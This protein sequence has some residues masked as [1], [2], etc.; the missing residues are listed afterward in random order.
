MNP[1]NKEFLNIDL[2]KEISLEMKFDYIIIF[3]VL[4]HLLIL[5]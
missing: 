4:E 1:S 2:Q 5:I 3:N